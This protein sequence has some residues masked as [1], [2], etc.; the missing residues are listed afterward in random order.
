MSKS[1]KTRAFIIERSAGVFNKKGYSGTSL[2]DIIEVTG[3]TKG[4]IYGNFENK[5]EVAVSA[6]LYS[7]SDLQKR[8][9]EEIK[10][11]KPGYQRLMAFTGFYRK[12]W[13][14]LFDRGGSPIQNASIEADDNIDVLKVPVQQSIIGWAKQISDIIEEGMAQGEFRPYLN[15]PDY[16]FTIISQLEGGI[17]L[18]KIM[19]N[20]HLLFLSIDRVE[21][22]INKELKW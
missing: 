22:I 21:Y 10:D 6:Y 8:V 3:L 13:K 16:A 4:S 7:F 19:N 9:H 20:P 12:N 5:D 11:K 15:A 14:L 17:M 1:E 2:S 18:G